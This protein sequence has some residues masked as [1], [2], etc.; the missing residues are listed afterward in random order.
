MSNLIQSKVALLQR[1]I[2]EVPEIRYAGDPILRQKVSDTSVE[3]GGRISKQLAKV[4]LKYRDVTGFG[5][6][7]AAPQIG[8]KASVFITYIDDVIET[9]INPKITEFSQ[10]KNYYKE[11]CMSAGILAADV[12]RP[13]WIVIE[14][15]D[16]D[17]KS[18]SQKFEGFKARL[19]QH[20]EAHLRGRLNLDDAC[21]GGIEFAIF[22]PLKEKLRTSRQ[23][24]E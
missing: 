15:T 7:L 16:L 17:G 23:D 10:D 9:F 14:W 1:I 19:L 8:E 4:L 24:Q 5:R 21:V 3:E 12:E 18:H 20:E 2:S 6:G 13:V 11:L 22:D